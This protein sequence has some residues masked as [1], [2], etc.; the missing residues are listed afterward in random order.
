MNTTGI[1]LLIIGILGILASFFFIIKDTLS[2]QKNAIRIRLEKKELI[3][4]AIY[5]G[6]SAIGFALLLSSAFLLHPEWADVLIHSTGVYKGENI[7]YGGNIALVVIG[8]FLFGG[9]LALFVPT[10]W[11]H[12]FKEKKDEKQAKLFRILYYVSIPLLI[13]SFP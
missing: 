3:R 12:I 4:Y 10:F 2:F 1:A 6:V 11:I 7:S 13:I 9:S 5:V 8:G